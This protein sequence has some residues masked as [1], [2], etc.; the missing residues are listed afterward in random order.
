[1]AFVL[2]SEGTYWWPLSIETPSSTGT[3]K[4]RRETFEL[5]F[6]RLPQSRV[7]EIMAGEYELRCAMAQN[8]FPEIKKLI[9]VAREHAAE[10]VVGWRGILEKDG[11]EEIPF[12]ITALENLLQV[13]GMPGI[14]LATYGETIPKAKE[15]N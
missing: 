8:D 15:K 7:E 9:G 4:Y 2:Q 3:G 6:R 1:M 13:P 12:S 10:V 14:I 5:E 11:G